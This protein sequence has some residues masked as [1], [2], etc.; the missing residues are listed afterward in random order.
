M[1]M[2]SF[3]FRQST[4][5]APVDLSKRYAVMGHGQ[6]SPDGQIALNGNARIDKSSGKYDTS[7]TGIVLVIE[8]PKFC[9]K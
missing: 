1:T 6:L 9:L 2:Q 4:K 8:G 5:A 7:G 3:S